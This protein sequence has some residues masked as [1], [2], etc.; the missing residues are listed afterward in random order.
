MKTTSY[1]I[2]PPMVPPTTIQWDT[3][4]VT[5]MFPLKEKH[6]LR[7]VRTTTLRI[8][9]MNEPNHP[10]FTNRL[11]NI[12]SL[13]TRRIQDLRIT[14]ATQKVQG[15][16]M[17]LVDLQSQRIREILIEIKR[18]MIKRRRWLAENQFQLKLSHLHRITNLVFLPGGN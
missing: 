8:V 17:I 7:I 3:P 2:R 9:A 12:P 6:T 18:K 14:P 13:R 11:V 10:N 5:P 4:L 16:K 15:I 1:T